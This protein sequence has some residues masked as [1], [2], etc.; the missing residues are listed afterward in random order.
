MKVFKLLI[1]LFAFINSINAGDFK[2]ISSDGKKF[3][4]DKEMV[5]SL[6]KLINSGLESDEEAQEFPIPGVSAQTLNY[7]VGQGQILNKIYKHEKSKDEQEKITIYQELSEYIIKI[8]TDDLVDLLNAAN[9]LD[10]EK[11]LHLLILK[12]V[13]RILK[14]KTEMQIFENSKLAM[15]LKNKILKDVEEEQKRLNNLLLDIIE[16]AGNKEEEKIIEEIKYLLAQGAD[17]NAFDKDGETILTQFAIGRSYDLKVIKFLLTIPQININQKSKNGNTILHL[18]ISA[19]SIPFLTR[20]E[21]ILKLLI[22]AGA[23]INS[24]N[25]EHSTPLMMA[26]KTANRDLVKLLLSIKGIDLNIKNKKGETAL[27]IAKRIAENYQ[28]FE[29]SNIRFQFLKLKKIIELLKQAG[30]KEVLG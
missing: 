5:R 27:D 15:P 23:D 7:L 20:I 13:E 30:A 17:I 11:L 16:K 25:N 21:Q 12:S 9:Y 22:D 3:P 29:A 4:V 2:L 8:P 18:F 24:L 26:V 6:S 28:K 19:R 14:N 1:I 10:S